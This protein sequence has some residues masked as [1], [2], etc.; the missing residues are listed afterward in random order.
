MLG[1]SIESHSEMDVSQLVAFL[2]DQLRKGD[3][4]S[5]IDFSSLSHQY[6]T[7]NSSSNPTSQFAQ[8]VDVLPLSPNSN[9]PHEQNVKVDTQLSDSIARKIDSSIVQTM[10]RRIDFLESS[11]S[12]IQANSELSSSQMDRNI[13]KLENAV[14]ESV[15]SKM[16]NENQ[17]LLEVISQLQEQ[18]NKQD[19]SN[20]NSKKIENTVESISS[21]L[22]NELQSLQQRIHGLESSLSNFRS[23]SE[24]SSSQIDRNMKKLENSLTDAFE[25]KLSNDNQKLSE[26]FSKL[27]AQINNQD[28]IDR[29]TKKLESSIESISNKVD[30]EL[31]SLQQRMK[32][33]E[34]SLSNSDFSSQIDRSVKKLEDRV[35]GKLNDET[36]RVVELLSKLQTQSNKQEQIDLNTKRLEAFIESIS[37][38]IDNELQS[39]QQRIH[40][41]ESSISDAKVESEFARQANRDLTSASNKL[42]YDNQRILDIVS[43]IQVQM[44]D[45]EESQVTSQRTIE[46][47]LRNAQEKN[48]EVLSLKN[49]ISAL[50]SSLSSLQ[51]NSNIKVL[52]SELKRQHQQSL[53]ALEA[54]IIQ[55]LEKFAKRQVEIAFRM[56]IVEE[57]LK[58]EQEISIKALHAIMD[59]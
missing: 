14:M 51:L 7:N 59:D 20:R 27:Q 25:S 4:S 40:G 32:E 41:L 8:K 47:Q 10:Q 35:E 9:I 50:E 42:N 53:H 26:M 48:N 18:L 12:S 2:V 36:Q 6:S 24:F 57:A 38:K 11:L 15:Q 30:T 44:K 19:Q 45:Y 52:E 58:N 34:F 29:N 46:V 22:D 17:R 49:R 5:A 16:K 37:S 28:Q 33:L 55:E 43:Q 21:K 39:L 1:P 54:H 3:A 13:K 56:G 31:Q 23:M